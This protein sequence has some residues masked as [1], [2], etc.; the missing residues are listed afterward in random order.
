MKL[1]AKLVWVGILVVLISM[2]LS[3]GMMWYLIRQQ[4]DKDARQRSGQ[5]V[6]MI[7]QELTRQ[8]A[9]VLRG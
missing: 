4:N 9:N 5:L 6:D 1:R 8:G 2:L 3:T 7:R